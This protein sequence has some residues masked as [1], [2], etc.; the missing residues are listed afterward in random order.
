MRPF[1]GLL[2]LSTLSVPAFAED[3][4]KADPP[5]QHH[6]RATWEQHFTQANLKHDGHLTLEEAKRG[7]ANVARHFDDI[8]AAHK[9]Y[10]TEDDIRAWRVRRRAAHRATKPAEDK[11]RQGA[12]VQSVDPDF[13]TLRVSSKPIV[14]ASTGSPASRQ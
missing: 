9:G 13:R 14:P 6:G 1:L 7:D 3:P 2:L 10:V 12:A 5:S 4:P 11:P 8:D